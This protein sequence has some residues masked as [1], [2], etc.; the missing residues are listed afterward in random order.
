MPKTSTVNIH[1]STVK[2]MKYNEPYNSVVSCDEKGM[3]EY[4]SAED[5]KIPT[6]LDYKYKSETDLY[7]LAKVSALS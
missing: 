2:S 5:F 3:I 1:R 6:D 4:W 7:D